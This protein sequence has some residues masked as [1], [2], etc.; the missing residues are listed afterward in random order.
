[1]YFDISSIHFPC[2]NMYFLYLLTNDMHAKS[3]FHIDTMK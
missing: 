3:C 2:G 1:M